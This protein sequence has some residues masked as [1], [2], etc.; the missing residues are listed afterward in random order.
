MLSGEEDEPMTTNT[1][2]LG[3]ILRDAE[4]EVWFCSWCDE[5]WDRFPKWVRKRKKRMGVEVI[6]RHEEEEL[7]R[8]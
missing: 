5:S 8:G 6:F 2:G 7:G 3:A 4:F 1:L